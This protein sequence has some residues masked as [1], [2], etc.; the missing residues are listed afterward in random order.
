MFG[1][2]E[3][4]LLI[5]STASSVWNTFI[6]SISLNKF[7]NLLHNKISEP[8]ACFPFV[9]KLILKKKQGLGDTGN[10]S[11]RERNK[12][13]FHMATNVENKICIRILNQ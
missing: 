9:C 3:I 6:P 11:T 12:F 4:F 1:Y 5:N 10:N 2:F 8:Y 7:D 13:R